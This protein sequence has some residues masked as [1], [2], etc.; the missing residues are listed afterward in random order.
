MSGQITEAGKKMLNY[1]YD[2]Y[3]M[4]VH[5]LGFHSPA[6]RRAAEE[7]ARHDVRDA[8]RAWE[9]AQEVLGDAVRRAERRLGLPWAEPAR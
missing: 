7:V 5:Q 6:V 9:A 3:P 8:P 1:R 4:Y 2:P